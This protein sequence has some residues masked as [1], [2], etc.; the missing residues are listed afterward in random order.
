MNRS[1]PRKGE[2]ILGNGSSVC[3]KMKET[4]SSAKL[5][6]WDIV[7]EAL[8]SHGRTMSKG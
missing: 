8:G 3:A 1:S 5:K 7:L 2:R 4:I 6:G